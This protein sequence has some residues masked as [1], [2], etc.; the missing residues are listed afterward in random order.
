MNPSDIVYVGAKG[1]VAAF[2]KLDGSL[3]WKTSLKETIFSSGTGFVTLL[4]DGDRV[5]AH[6]FGELHCLDALSGQRL[7]KNELEGLG[8]DIASVAVIGASAPSIAALAKH[9]ANEQASNS[10]ASSSTSS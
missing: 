3:L 4:V 5:Y 6:S 10:A 1:H 7:W 9:R 8:Y 2:S